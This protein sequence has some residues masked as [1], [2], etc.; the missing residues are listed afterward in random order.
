ME[1]PAPRRWFSFRL[2]TL[3][4]LVLACSV[5]FGWCAN[6]MSGFRRQQSA[7]EELTNRQLELKIVP[8]GPSW[9]RSLAGDK[10]LVHV[11]SVGAKYHAPPYNRVSR[12]L[13]P[14]E[15]TLLDDLLGVKSLDIPLAAIDDEQLNHILRHTDLTRLSL[16]GSHFGKAD[17]RRVARLTKLECLDL[18]Y[19]DADDRDL[20]AF[21]PMAQLRALI[22]RETKATGQGLWALAEHGMID[23]LELS[24]HVNDAGLEQIGRFPS[25][26]RLDIRSD[27]MTDAGVARLRH[28]TRLTR[29]E[30]VSL[31]ITSSVLEQLSGMTELTELSLAG[32][33]IGDGDLRRLPVLSKLAHLML[34]NTAVGNSDLRGMPKL[35]ALV[36]LTLDYT[37]ITDDGLLAL[38]EKTSSLETIWLSNTKVTDAGLMQLLNLP[39]LKLVVAV[40]SQVTSQGVARFQAEAKKRSRSIDVVSERGR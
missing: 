4:L 28:L 8:V 10:L 31:Q 23:E 3:L 30:L 38:P 39:K 33:Q 1:V 15:F 16:V 34:A 32:A 36:E 9:V 6:Q 22:L 17:W 35:G 12:S 18:S 26:T 29:L 25:L 2:R 11:E 40:D 27:R 21:G 19:T 24:P 37:V 13:K 14:G 7:I 5:L 20:E